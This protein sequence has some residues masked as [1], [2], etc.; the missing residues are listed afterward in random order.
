MSHLDLVS[1]HSKEKLV[2]LPRDVLDM[3]N[4]K[5]LFLEGNFLT[6]VPPALFQKLPK[7]MWL[8]LR[9]NVLESIPPT[10]AY[11]QCLENLLLTNNNLRA[12]PNE[13]GLVP[14]L[15]ALQVSENPL[16]YPPRKIVVEGTKMIKNFLKSQYDLQHAHATEDDTGEDNESVKSFESDNGVK[17]K[18]SSS[19]RR[20]FKGTSA[21]ELRE[22]LRKKLS[23]PMDLRPALNVKQIKDSSQLPT[24]KEEP[25]KIVHSVKK[26]GSKLSLKSYFHRV[27]EDESGKVDPVVREGWLNQLRILLNDQER[28]IQ[29]ERNL[30]ALSDWRTKSKQQS[31]KI[32][33]EDADQRLLSTA[34]FAMYKG[35][36]KIPTREQLAAQ[37]NDSL[38]EKRPS[39]SDMGRA[40]NNSN[41]EKLINDLIEQLKKIEVAQRTG[42]GEKQSSRSEL[43]ATENQ[44]KMIMDIQKKLLQL[45]SGSY[46]TI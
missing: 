4:L 12:L 8:D 18:R 37:L 27:G 26:K 35:F 24:V 19:R 13:L 9:N 25:I 10:I 30:R 33:M 7:L 36:L 11:H 34:P 42:S 32:F 6:E 17:K 16:E 1:D 41:I 5:M 20:K 22:K 21:S 40:S 31:P 28:I 39:R 44:I 3:S 2:S 45:K 29:Q 14:K 15:K 38:K 46:Q 43:Q 23:D